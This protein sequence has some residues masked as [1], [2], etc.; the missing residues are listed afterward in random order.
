M[1]EFLIVL[2]LILIALYE[3]DDVES[4]AM[5]LGEYIETIRDDLASN[6]SMFPFGKLATLFAGAVVVAAFITFVL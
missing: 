2:V 4:L 1:I 5:N 6:P 3:W